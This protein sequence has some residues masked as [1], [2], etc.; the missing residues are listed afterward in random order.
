M[1]FDIVLLILFP[2]LSVFIS[3]MFGTN[4]LISALLFT[5]LP[6]FYLSFRTPKA[7]LRSIIFAAPF[8]IIGG[9]FFDHLAV[10]D[11]SWY[12]PTVFP[13]RVF[14]TVPLEDLIWAFLLVYLILIFY[15]HFFD[16]SKHKIVGT[17]MK[18]FAYIVI[19]L[20][21]IF[22]LL[23]FNGS[24][25]LSIEYFYL[26]G[27]VTL[28]L[29]PTIVFLVKF[30]GLVSKFF[31]TAAYFFYVGLLQEL[32]AL[33]LGHWSFPGKNF[34][35]WITMLGYRFPYEEFFF[36]LIVFSSCVLSYFEFFDDD[37]VRV[38]KSW[39]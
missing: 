4:F 36:W 10:L 7:I 14:N 28:I 33:Q 27:G 38:V 17:R 30:P 25:L 5:G 35:G 9:L 26:K 22:L 24:A 16:K 21:T 2:I 34:I 31:K 6:A 11:N 1:R 13:F 18:Y 20:F 8:S 37:R 32:A 12:V 29:L 3:L 15:E 39:S 19:S 23:V